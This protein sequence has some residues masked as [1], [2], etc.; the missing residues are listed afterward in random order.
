MMKKYLGI[1]TVSL[2][3]LAGVATAADTAA[4]HYTETTQQNEYRP[5]HKHG[6]A[7]QKD[8][9][10]H[11]K[12]SRKGEHKTERKANRLPYGLHD[13]DLSSKQKAQIE[14]IL[15]ERK[16][17]EQAPNQAEFAQRHAQM[18]QQAE[19][20]RN[21]R[22]QLITG[23]TFDEAAARRLIEERQN[24]HQRLMAEQ[25]QKSAEWE[26]QRLKDSHA[27]F[28]VLN[29]EQQKKWLEKQNRRHSKTGKMPEAS[30]APAAAQ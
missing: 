4:R 1:A 2:L 3:G 10:R 28:Q 6:K 13:L 29:A 9:D 18:Q 17:N 23:K 8:H 16:R 12:N 20:W 15:A 25:Q 14:K 30:N 7:H 19:I 26:L 22:Q 24:L 27:V 5:A 11:D 21:T